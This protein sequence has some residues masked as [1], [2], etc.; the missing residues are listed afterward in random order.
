M[1]ELTKR[2]ITGAAY[3]I[4]IILGVI[5]GRITF[6]AVYLIIMLWA[7]YEFYNLTVYSRF[8]K[9]IGVMSGAVI[10][11]FS[12]LF[13][14][15][16]RNLGLLTILIPLF[17]SVFI[18]F[19]FANKHNQ[20]LKDITFIFFSLVY[21][22]LPFSLIHYLAVKGY[23]HYHWK[24]VLG[25]MILLWS[26]DTFA[27]I[28]G[29]LAGKHR[30]FPEISPK[31]TWEG[32]FGGVLMTIIASIV[33]SYTTNSL[34]IVNWILIGVITGITGTLGDLTESKIKRNLDVKNSGTFLP[35]HGG[36]LDRVDSMLISLPCVFLYLYL[37]HNVF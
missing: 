26:N 35:G 22:V 17:L 24:I 13:I 14:F 16:I 29:T 18:C 30:L 7:C 11:T 20:L 4:L 31:K 6:F 8:L 28:T 2:T 23:N 12:H 25:Y 9:V 5:A 32:T 19:L 34:T 37:T 1:N 21:I 27:Y 10:Y 36:M 33:I 15:G 3:V